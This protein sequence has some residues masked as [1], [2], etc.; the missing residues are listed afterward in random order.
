M[1]CQYAACRQPFKPKRPWQ[2][3]C[4]PECKGA[5]KAEE[6]RLMRETWA[7]FVAQLGEVAWTGKQAAKD[8]QRFAVSIAEA[9]KA[10]KK[11]SDFMKERSTDANTKT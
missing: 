8:L 10:M 1:K 6:E 2:K 7:L 9:A 4:R 5:A 3:F 11:I